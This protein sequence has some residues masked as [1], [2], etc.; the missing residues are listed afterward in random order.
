MSAFIIAGLLHVHAKH[1]EFVPVEPNQ[2]DF[3]RR[4]PEDEAPEDNTPS[5]DDMPLH[6]DQDDEDGDDRSGDVIKE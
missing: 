5:E 1:E 3:A 6:T 4:E 2:Y